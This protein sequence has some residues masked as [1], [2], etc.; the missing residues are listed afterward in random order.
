[1]PEVATSEI[2]RTTDY[3]QF[4]LLETNRT[5]NKSHMLTLGKSIAEKPELLK[6]RPVLVNENMEVIEGQH[7]LSA[8]KELGV[9][10][11]YQVGE[12]LS[13][14]DTQRFNANQRNWTPLDYARSYAASGKPVYQTY[15]DLRIEYPYPHR[16]MMAYVS[17]FYGHD[18]NR[19]FNR[20]QLTMKYSLEEVKQRLDQLTELVDLVPQ[21]THTVQL[22]A[23]VHQ[24]LNH[25]DY[26]HEKFVKKLALY[27]TKHI[28]RYSHVPE[29][30]RALEAVYNERTSFE[31]QIK[32]F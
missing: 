8:A 4:K 18:Q 32:I 24:L 31:D 5:I 20:G 11:Y 28:R 17:G 3:D 12:G 1:M 6:Y 10:V 19:K 15:I 13:I 25:P 23:A 29:Y 22:H 2:K 21:E 26:E 16:T 7:R 30:A 27:A 14:Q 9:P